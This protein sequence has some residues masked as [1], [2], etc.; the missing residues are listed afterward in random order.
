MNILTQN[1][2]FEALASERD[3]SQFPIDYDLVWAELGYSRR[4]N[5]RRR[6]VKSLIENVDFAL[7]TSE[8]WSQ[9]G[10]LKDSISL[11]VDGF[12]MLC[13]LA[14]TPQGREVRQYFIQVE[15]AYR[16]QLERQL[17]ASPREADNTR[18]CITFW[19]VHQDSGIKDPYYVRDVIVA[20]YEHQIISGLV[21]I[22]RLTYEDLL[23]DFRSQTGADTSE[24][25]PEKR[26]KF[27]KS[28]GKKNKREPQVSDGVQLSLFY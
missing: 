4:D 10:R 12:K 6:L 5:A 2:V 28:K 13:M 11:S 22:T 3:G 20:S 26:R 14:E 24:L 17:Q 21:C 18:Y 27:R 8:E 15:K 9:D 7:L 19:K 1:F 16:A 23:E 25:P